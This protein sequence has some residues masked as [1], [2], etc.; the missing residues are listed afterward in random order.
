MKGKKQPTREN[1]IPPH[2]NDKAE[3]NAAS[4]IKE[5]QLQNK[6]L[7]KIKTTIKKGNLIQN[8]KSDKN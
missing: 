1:K 3:K 8:I 2:E 4:F 7:E 5:L 6:A